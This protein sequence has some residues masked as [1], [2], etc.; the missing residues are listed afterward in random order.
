MGFLPGNRQ[1]GGAQPSRPHFVSPWAHHGLF[2]E[3]KGRE[4]R[5]GSLPG[6]APAP[7]AALLPAS[8]GSVRACAAGKALPA[9]EPPRCSRHMNNE[10][11][12]T[13]GGMPGSAPDYDSVHSRAPP[14]LHPDKALWRE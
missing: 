9:P 8:W 2:H 4:R 5:G 7:R 12:Q 3:D 1:E 10:A 13:Q 11:S 6:P 14:S